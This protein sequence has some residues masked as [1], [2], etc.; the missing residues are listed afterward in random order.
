MR[1]ICGEF[2]ADVQPFGK[3]YGDRHAYVTI[4][5]YLYAVA[6]FEFYGER[7]LSGSGKQGDCLGV[8]GVKT[9]LVLYTCGADPAEY[10]ATVW[11][12]MLSGDFRFFRV[13]VCDTLYDTIFQ[14]IKK[15]RK[16]RELNV[17]VLLIGIF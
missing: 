15:G 4:T 11:G 16:N 6:A 7:Y 1:D 13:P 17:A 12:T 10:L 8:V 3:G 5:M 9:G 2:D 14:T